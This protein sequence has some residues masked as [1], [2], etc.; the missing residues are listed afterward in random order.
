[1]ALELDQNFE[2][3]HG[4]PAE[5]AEGVGRVTANNPGPFTFHGTN[6]YIVGRERLAVI[7]P[8]PADEAHLAALV[9]AIGGGEVT[10]IFVSHTHRDH[11]PL[12]ARL[13]EVTGA[14]TLAEGSHR[15]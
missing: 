1:M 4:R 3:A 14:P 13:S 7:D 5:G 11:S 2:P 8:G 10:H 9:E 12:A 6:S 15:P